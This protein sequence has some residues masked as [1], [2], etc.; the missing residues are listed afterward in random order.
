MLCKMFSPIFFLLGNGTT[1]KLTILT[2]TVRPIS[3]SY[4]TQ[5][6]SSLQAVVRPSP[7]NVPMMRNK[8]GNLKQGIGSLYLRV[9]K[10]NIPRE[11]EE[12]GSDPKNHE[13][14]HQGKK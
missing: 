10:G 7:K 3:F 8:C 13:S 12:T 5:T 14:Y 2:F 4:L 6:N 9:W 11:L 1:L